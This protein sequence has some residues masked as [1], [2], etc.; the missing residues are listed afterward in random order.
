MI[1]SALIAIAAQAAPPA[2]AIALTGGTVH[3]MVPGEAPRIAT[4]LVLGDR[5]RA[6]DPHAE[7]PA[8][9]L[10]IDLSGKHLIPGLIDGMVNH[11]ADH[12]RLYVTSGVTL[13]R[14]IGN[15]L[16]RIL[17]ERDKGGKIGLRD[18]GP[19]PAIWCAGG[20]LDGSPPS[21]TAAVVLGS[22]EEAADKLARLFDLEPDFVSFHAGLAEPVWRKVIE[23]AH[24]HGLQVWGPK[25]AGVEMAKMAEAG[26]D[27][28]YHL[29][30]FLPA[31]KS[32]PDV[33]LEEL[34]VGVDALAG[35]KVAITPTLAVFA[36][37][38]IAPPE[39]PP[40]LAYLGPMYVASWLADAAMRSKVM[41]DEKDYLRT[42][43]RVVETQGKLLKALHERGITLLPGSGSPNAWLF[44]GEAL[45][46]EL[47]MWARAGIPKET[48]LAMATAGAAKALGV[49]KDRGTIEAGK[50][51]DLVVLRGDPGADLGVLHSP[52]TVVLRGRVLDRAAMDA[53]RKDLADTQK[54]LQ[55]EAFKPLEIPDP[56]L[57]PGEGGD[58]VLRGTVETRTMGQR[59]SGESFAVVRIQDGSLVYCAR[60]VTPGTAS[61][62]RTE[63]EMQ[64]TLRDGGVAGFDIGIRAGG[65][66]VTVKGM[67]V[68]NVLNIERRVDGTFQGNVPVKD[69]LAF[70]DVGSVTAEIALGQRTSEGRFKVLFFDDLDPATGNWELHLD[71]D[72]THLVHTHNGTL[73]VRFAADGSVVEALREEGRGI[74]STR[75]LSTQA[76]DRGLPLPEKK[77]G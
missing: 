42:G 26:Q 64:E 45:Q 60:V 65:R 54:R 74:T 7:I 66:L 47:G 9:A 48:V 62:G 67:Q 18:R 13:V 73:K 16:A 37:R 44:P 34:R 15:D 75:P 38:L 41:T 43:L 72:G 12:D 57:P 19:G 39:H 69:L 22:P 46:D 17:A 3:T 5:I 55:A 32:W 53:L 25:I 27:G 77:R 11:D 59:I 63:V 61:T 20:V 76:K 30:A 50:I 1:L 70:V 35:K 14:D 24:G 21:T 68:G 51:A 36:K 33:S 2:K 56:P 8:D 71:K 40:E 28:L 29:E 58:V 49:D 10:R 23:L 6:V 31:G 4:V 52:E